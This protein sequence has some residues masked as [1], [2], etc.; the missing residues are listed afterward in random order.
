MHD[1]HA[2]LYLAATGDADGFAMGNFAVVRDGLTRS[3]MEFLAA[4][5]SLLNDCFF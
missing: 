4:R 2:E 1:L 5:T 3:Q